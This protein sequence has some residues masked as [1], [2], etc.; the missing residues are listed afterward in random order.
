MRYCASEVAGL[1]DAHSQ[2]TKCSF[3]EF[4]KSKN[5]QKVVSHW[6][7]GSRTWKWLMSRY[8]T[9]AF[10]RNG[11]EHKQ[12]SERFSLCQSGW[13]DSLFFERSWKVLGQR[14]STGWVHWHRQLLLDQ[15]Q[16]VTMILCQNIHHRQAKQISAHPGK[17]CLQFLMPVMAYTKGEKLTNL[18]HVFLDRLDF[19]APTWSQA[20]VLFHQGKLV[21]VVVVFKTFWC[22]CKCG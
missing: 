3:W 16:R 5:V 22:R 10:A 18:C 20:L 21:H 13:K 8:F 17:I 6:K 11:L 9:W 19:N 4:I 1:R 15:N 12:D 14:Q 2:Y 7:C